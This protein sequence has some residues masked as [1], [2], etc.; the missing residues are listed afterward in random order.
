M[1]VLHTEYGGVDVSL[2]AEDCLL[3]AE[4]LSEYDPHDELAPLASTAY[5]LGAAFEA[6]AVVTW[7]QGTLPTEHAARLTL[8]TVRRGIGAE[9]LAL[10]KRA[11]EEAPDTPASETGSLASG[12]DAA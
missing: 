9:T 10:A 3:I 8:E 2:T 11:H 12:K 7:G 4:A 5:A 1:R 6:L